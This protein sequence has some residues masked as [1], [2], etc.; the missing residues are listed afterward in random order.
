MSAEGARGDIE[1]LHPFGVGDLLAMIVRPTPR[2]A[3][4]L[5]EYDARMARKRWSE[6][7]PRLQILRTP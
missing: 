2:R 1:L 6:T 3:D 7:W 5:E 4:R